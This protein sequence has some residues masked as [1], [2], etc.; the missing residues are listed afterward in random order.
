MLL[1]LNSESSEFAKYL[2]HNLCIRI[3][4]RRSALSRVARFWEERTTSQ[5]DLGGW[6]E[7]ARNSV[8]ASG[9]KILFQR[10]CP[11]PTFSTFQIRL[12]QDENTP[13]ATSSDNHKE[14]PPSRD[15]CEKFMDADR[16][17]VD[18]AWTSSWRRAFQQNA[19]LATL[20]TLVGRTKRAKPTNGFLATYFLTKFTHKG[21][22]RLNLRKITRCPPN[23][24]LY[25]T[26]NLLIRFRCCV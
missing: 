5:S 1:K 11:W 25:L 18:S 6:L 4:Q 22:R 15:P 14:E 3:L 24:D 2:R 13:P 20:G 26:R 17:R 19:R 7:E 21:I 23:V 16:S 9:D 8:A 12:F 10:F